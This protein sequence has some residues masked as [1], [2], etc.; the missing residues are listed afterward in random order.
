MVHNMNDEDILAGAKR[1][2]TIAILALICQ[3]EKLQHAYAVA[4]AHIAELEE[5]VDEEF[6][7]GVNAA[8]GED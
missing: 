1:G 8:S 5:Q 3:F 6:W 2:E 4:S 7:R